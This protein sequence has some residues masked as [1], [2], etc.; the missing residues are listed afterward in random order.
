MIAPLVIAS[1]VSG[2]FVN[3]LRTSSLDGELT[4]SHFLLLAALLPAGDEFAMNFEDVSGSFSTYLSLFAA[5]LRVGSELR[6]E[7]VASP[8]ITTEQ[9]A[10]GR[11]YRLDLRGSHNTY[12]RYYLFLMYDDRPPLPCT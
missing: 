11:S 9:G 2:R 6:R 1:F 12:L 4:R 3:I 8:S 5:F 7:H 10:S